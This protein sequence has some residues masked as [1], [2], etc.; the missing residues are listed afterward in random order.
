VEKKSRGE[1]RDS[2]LVEFVM[3][4]QRMRCITTP[5][6]VEDYYED[7]GAE[8]EAYDD[9]EETFYDDYYME[10]DQLAVSACLNGTDC[11]DCGGVANL[12]PEDS[13]VVICT[14]TCPYAHDGQF[15]DRSR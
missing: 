7:G 2:P 8:G 13:S 14:N 10:D 15:Q 9:E 1:W 6:R 11:T 3:M 4:A 5:M 12:D